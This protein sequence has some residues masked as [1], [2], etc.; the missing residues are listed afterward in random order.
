MS[1]PGCPYYKRPEIL[2][3]HVEE[4]KVDLIALRGYASYRLTIVKEGTFLGDVA[5]INHFLRA[6]GN[7][8]CYEL[9]TQFSGLIKT[10]A[11]TFRLFHECHALA[12]A[13]EKVMHMVSSSASLV[14]RNFS[15]GW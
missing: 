3:K 13:R 12:V 9:D 4:G 11:C 14:N 2:T 7:T 5:A 8:S 15:S 10:L 1:T 6:L